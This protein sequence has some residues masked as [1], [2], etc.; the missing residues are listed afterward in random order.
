MATSGA[1]RLPE[2][3]KA[4]AAPV[5]RLTY[6]GGVPSREELPRFVAPMLARTGPVPV[7]V[8]WAFE[9][10]FDGMRLQLRRDERAVWLR[11][12]RGRDCTE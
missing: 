4:A 6:A 1:G 11:S 9:V 10:K 3:L 2:E 7:G 5:A 12:R 8:G